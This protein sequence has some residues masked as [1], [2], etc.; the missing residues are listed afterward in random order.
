MTEAISRSASVVDAS[1]NK[2]ATLVAAIRPRPV[3]QPHPPNREQDIEMHDVKALVASAAV[4][5]GVTAPF[6][7]TTLCPLVQGFVLLPLTDAVLREITAACQTA[8]PKQPAIADVAQGVAQFA[9]QLSLS[10]PVAYVSTEFFGGTGGQDVVVWSSG[11]VA[12]L[13]SDRDG[14]T[15]EWPNSPVSQA[16]RAIGVEAI[17]GKDEFD[18]VGL[19]TY[20]STEGWAAAHAAS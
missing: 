20:R 2:M 5:T 13:L 3:A 1:G 7:S 4:L 14:E 19:G 12:L 8:E 17:G 16:L 10:G 18:T 9:S 15:I 11:R 6:G